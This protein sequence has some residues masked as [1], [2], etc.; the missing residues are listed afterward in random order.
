[1]VDV[2]LIPHRWVDGIVHL[3]STGDKDCTA[4]SSKL[5]HAAGGAFPEAPR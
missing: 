1:M 2:Q 3:R 5:V 4:A